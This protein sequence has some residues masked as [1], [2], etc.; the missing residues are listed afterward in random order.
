MQTS[1]KTGAWRSALGSIMALCLLVACTGGPPNGGPPDLDPVKVTAR[2][3]AP[4]SNNVWIETVIEVGF[5]EPVDASSIDAASAFVRAEDGTVLAATRELSDDGMLLRMV[6][7]ERP[8][9]VPTTLTAV[10]TEAITGLEGNALAVPEQPHSWAVPAWQLMGGPLDR[11]P[12]RSAVDPA[13]VVNH[14]GVIVVAWQ[15]QASDMSTPY[16]VFVSRWDEEQQ[17]W[18]ALGEALNAPTGHPGLEPSLAIDTIRRPVVAWR[19]PGQPT[20]WIRTWQESSS[21]WLAL[22]EP[23]VTAAPAGEYRR[24]RLATHPR[25]PGLAR[26]YVVDHE[27]PLFTY[28]LSSIWDVNGSAWI[29]L[30]GGGQ[31][32]RHGNDVAAPSMLLLEQGLVVLAWEESDGWGVQHVYVAV[33]GGEFSD[34]TYLGPDGVNTPGWPARDASLAMGSDEVPLVAWRE[35]QG[36]MGANHDL[37][38]ARWDDDAAAWVDLGGVL[39]LDPANA[40]GEPDLAVDP[41]DRPVVAWHENHGGNRDVHV[42]RWNEQDAAWEALGGVIDVDPERSAFEPR[43]AFDASGAPLV[44]WHEPVDGHFDV[45][46]GRWNGR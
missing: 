25:V 34:W 35:L 36:G 6:L 33:A 22:H 4:G 20:L 19:A 42:R 30:V 15:E 39:D 8:E 5:T 1:L 13:I 40:V 24:P 31:L 9:T 12:A 11:D 38:V 44:A 46:L 41:L 32:S 23:A 17:A 26:A 7:Q 29:G 27:A 2:V 45:Y 3:P 28:L 16:D 43:L 14:D 10:L 37:R 21:S 18:E